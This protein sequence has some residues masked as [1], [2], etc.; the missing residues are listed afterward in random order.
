MSLHPLYAMFAQCRYALDFVLGSV[1]LSRELSW[2]LGP[3][4]FECTQ[5]CSLST[6]QW[7]EECLTDYIKIK[8][9]G[10]LFC[11]VPSCAL[12]AC[13]YSIQWQHVGAAVVGSM[14]RLQVVLLMC[15]VEWA[16]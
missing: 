14:D 1:W 8:R 13:M 6:V 15:R 5:I 16:S 11:V 3:F 2:C 12:H 4:R 7:G 10:P 9:S